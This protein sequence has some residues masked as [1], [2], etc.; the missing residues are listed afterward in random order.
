MIEILASK[1]C[2]SLQRESGKVFYSGRVAFS[3]PSDLYVLGVNPGGDPDDKTETTVRQHT[4][5]VLHEAGELWAAYADESWK[6]RPAGTCGMQPRMLHLFEQI[7]RDPRRTP[8][9]NLVFTRS[10]RVAGLA[11]NLDELEELCWPFH[12][13]V[14][15][16]LGSRV[17]IC[18]GNDAGKRVRRRLSADT[19]LATFVEANERRWI[20]RAHRSA[21]GMVVLTLTHPSIADW[22]NP[23]TD[24]SGLVL[25]VLQKGVP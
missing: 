3:E 2:A 6:G 9:S 19:G 8:C 18:L 14:I 11:G 10:P 1:I 21:S 25:E 4:D 13:E 20:S 16:R 7:G 17:I 23:S 15:D 24:P 22:T 12:R 5:F